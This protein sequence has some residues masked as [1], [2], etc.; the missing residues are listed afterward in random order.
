MI[1]IEEIYNEY[2]KVVYRYLFCLTQNSDKAEE[3]TQETFYR[4][5][6]KIDKFEGNC[7]ISSWLCQIAKNL[8]LDELKKEKRKTELN[9]EIDIIDK[10]FDLE[11]Q[12]IS[13]EEKILLYKKI[14]NLDNVTKEVLILRIN[15][16]LSFK[17]IGL[18]FNKSENW[19][20]VT[21]YRGKQKLKEGG[22]INEG[23]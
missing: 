7:K 19:A 4:A 14:H 10:E 1:N 20:R 17:E 15:G 5:V 23:L 6:Q 12:V 9:E 2:F 11:N 8:Y 18:I 13:Q 3:L 21:F 16:E 22:N